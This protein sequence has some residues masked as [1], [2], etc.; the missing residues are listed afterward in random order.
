MLVGLSSR[1]LLL[2]AGWLSLA[3]PSLVLVHVLPR[4]AVVQSGEL[5]L[6]LLTRH[7]GANTQIFQHVPTDTLGGGDF[8]EA[9]V[10]FF[11]AIA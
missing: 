9:C 3:C 10:C 2:P 1:D 11:K 6:Q 8:I 5:G 7:C 4:G